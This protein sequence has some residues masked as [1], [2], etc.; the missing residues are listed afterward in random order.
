[1]RVRILVA[2][3]ILEPIVADDLL[4]AP[5]NDRL[6]HVLSDLLM[7]RQALSVIVDPTTDRLRAE[8]PTAS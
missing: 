6:Q 5:Q 7:L 2:A 1:M 8:D 3:E 4:P